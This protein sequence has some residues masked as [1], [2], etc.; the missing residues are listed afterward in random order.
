MPLHPSQRNSRGE[1][2][3]NLS[4]HMLHQSESASLVQISQGGSAAALLAQWASTKEGL[5]LLEATCPHLSVERICHAMTNTWSARH[6]L[7][8]FSR[9]VILWSTFAEK[10]FKRLRTRYEEAIASGLCFWIEDDTF[11]AVSSAEF[12]TLLPTLPTPA[13]F[14]QP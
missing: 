2:S 6:G 4:T 7:L 9:G 8:L 11:R 10:H 5:R 3:K 13:L 1:E 14:R 12:L